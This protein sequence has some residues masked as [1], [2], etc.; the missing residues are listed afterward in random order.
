M[1]KIATGLLACMALLDGA[2]AC[3]AAA[4]PSTQQASYAAIMIECRRMYWGQRSPAVAASRPMF[5]EGCFRQ[6]TGKHPWEAGVT[7]YPTMIRSGMSRR[8]TARR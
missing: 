5:I 3:L 8:T 4:K 7:V 6:R 2:T 1:P